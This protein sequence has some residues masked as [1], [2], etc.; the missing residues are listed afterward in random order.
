MHMQMPG[1]GEAHGGHGHGH[2]GH[3]GHRKPPMVAMA[4]IMI[5]WLFYAA[6][7]TCFLGAVNRIA[8][9]MQ[10]KAR[11]KVLTKVPEALT[12]D[13]RAYLLEKVAS[14]ALHYW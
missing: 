10:L 9:A 8:A 2:H 3:H 11:V 4:M 7:T 12:E 5:H 14:S 6:A 13:E 1:A